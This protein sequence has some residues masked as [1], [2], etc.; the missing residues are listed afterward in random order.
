MQNLDS[1][2]AAQRRPRTRVIAALLAFPAVSF[3]VCQNTNPVLQQ[4]CINLSLIHI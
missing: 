1:F 2:M 4:Q 3:A